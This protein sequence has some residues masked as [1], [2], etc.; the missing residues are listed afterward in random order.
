MDNNKF[1]LFFIAQSPRVVQPI[2]YCGFNS[3]SVCIKF[4]PHCSSM[5]DGMPTFL[6]KII[7][8]PSLSYSL[9]LCA[10]FSSSF[11]LS[12][13]L[14]S[15]ESCCCHLGFTLWSDCCVLH[16]FAIWLPAQ[17][18]ICVRLYWF[19]G[20][21]IIKSPSFTWNSVNQW[22]FSPF[23]CIFPFTFNRRVLYVYAKD[24]CRFLVRVFPLFNFFL[25]F[26]SAILGKYCRFRNC[27]RVTKP[28]F[29]AFLLWRIVSFRRN[30]NV[31]HLCA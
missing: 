13:I 4:L 8:N 24:L 3:F 7:S 31:A 17:C 28:W 10:F 2:E 23:A 19:D 5:T 22:L 11:L 1:K 21:K 14:P 18:L 20:L 16:F 25:F 27:M 15:A 29:I 26:C 6:R 9:H 12:L 30:L